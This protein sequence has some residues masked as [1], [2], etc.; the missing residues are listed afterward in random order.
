MISEWQF[1]HTFVGLSGGQ[2]NCVES[3]IVSRADCSSE[4]R[5]LEVFSNK[6]EDESGMN[7]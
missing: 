5:L 7:T 3:W 6:H 1:E 4:T 2:Y